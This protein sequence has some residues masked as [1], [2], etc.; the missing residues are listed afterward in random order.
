MTGQAWKRVLVDCF[1]PAELKEWRA[2]KEKLGPGFDHE[3]YAAAWVDYNARVQAALPL[4]PDSDVTKALI[5]EWDA[6]CAPYMA[7]ADEAMKG[8]A[9]PLWSFPMVLDDPEVF[10]CR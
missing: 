5:A 10:I 4:D 2:A 8:S 6:L 7:V 1:T 9:K 3:A